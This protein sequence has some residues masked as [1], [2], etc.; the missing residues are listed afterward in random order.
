MRGHDALAVA[1]SVDIRGV[2]EGDAEVQAPADRP[3]RTRR[4]STSPHPLGSSPNQN[5][6]PMAQ[7]PRPIALTSIPE[8]PKRLTNC[9]CIVFSPISAPAETCCRAGALRME[10]RRRIMRVW[11]ASRGDT[12]PQEARLAPEV[13]PRPSAEHQAASSSLYRRSQRLYGLM[14]HASCLIPRA[15]ETIS[16]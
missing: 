12:I 6:P 9:V 1:R 15:S 14:P 8:R 4:S 3:D 2:Q 11:K 7:Q 10:S 13:A 5:G 16:S